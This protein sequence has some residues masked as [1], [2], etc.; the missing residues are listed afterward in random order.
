MSFALTR[1]P[2]LAL[3]AAS[4]MFAVGC[5]LAG[6]QAA[7][8][9][10]TG[11]S[12]EAIVDINNSKV[13]RQSIGNCWLYATASWAESIAKSASPTNSELN[14]SESY[15]TYW[16]WFDKI[17]NG[18]TT[19]EEVSTGGWYSSSAEIISRYGVMTEGSFIASESLDEMSLRQKS[20]LAKINAS[21]KTGALKTQAARSDRALVRKE[22]DLAWELTPSVV[23]QLNRVFGTSVTRTL[24]RSTVSTSFTSIKRANTIRV[25]LRD[26]D[27]KQPVVV[28]LQDAIGTRTSSW[29]PR[30]GRYAW[31]MNSYPSSASA[32]RTM[33][34][35]VQRAMHDKQPVIMSWYVDF[36]ALDVYGRFAAPPTEPGRQGGHMV[37]VEDY[38]INDVPGFGT[39]K[40]GVNET[41]PA[42]LQAA[43]SSSAKIEFIRIKNSWGSYRPDRQFVIPGYHDLY[44]KYLDG[45]MKHC[46]Q[47]ED[48]T[49]STDDCYDDTPLND[50]VLPAGY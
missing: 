13:K 37:V 8:A 22:L 21:L 25:Q 47:N 46:T 15:W 33:L 35:R 14:M 17:A 7:E 2:L 50:F 43:L 30:A 45:P 28:T 3:L 48:D 39:L 18:S 20:A 38:Q 27:T 11:A 6:D 44:M 40:A 9:E 1:R 5:S 12:T 4:S 24:D 31:Q 19:G 23:S 29:G 42:A 41:R 32:R 26:P 36:N 34:A 16:D 49:D 10:E